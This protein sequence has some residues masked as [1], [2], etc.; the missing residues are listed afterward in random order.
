MH[1]IQ[2]H[3]KALEIH[4]KPRDK[5]ITEFDDYEIEEKVAITNANTSKDFAPL[6][7]NNDGMFDRLYFIHERIFL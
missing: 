4:D 3:F 1:S 7:A 6:D 2:Q 5:R